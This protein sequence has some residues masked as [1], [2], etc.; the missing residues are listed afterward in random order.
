MSEHLKLES[1]WPSLG[2]HNLDEAILFYLRL[3]F[4]LDWQWPEKD[5]TYASL[6]MSGIGFTI[7]RTD[8]PQNIQK[9][10]LY[11]RI[12]DVES[13]HFQ[14]MNNGIAVSELAETN[15]GMIEFHFTDPWGHFFTFGKSQQFLT[16]V[17]KGVLAPK[18]EEGRYVFTS[19]SESVVLKFDFLASFKEKEGITYILQ[20]E[21]AVELALTFEGEW[22]WI[23][24]G[25]HSKLE[26]TG[27]TAAI[28]HALSECKIPCN[29]VAAFYH[30]HIFVPYSRAIEAFNTINQINLPGL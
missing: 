22:A 2:V 29:V 8:N 7:V 6:H 27:L 5:P 14:L 15:Y 19:L 25:F 13:Y 10:D 26:M 1:V 30:D 11:F 24:L 18:I 3:G 20:K 23:S 28:S 16:E 17:D 9:T 12:N 4:K 21:T